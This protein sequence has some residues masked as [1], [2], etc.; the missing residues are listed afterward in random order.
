MAAPLNRVKR[1]ALI[2]GSSASIQSMISDIENAA[3]YNVNVLAT[4]PTGS[5]KELVAQALHARSGR[6]GP[7][8]SVNCAAIPRDL[9]EAEIFGHEKGAFTGAMARRIGRFEE[10]TNGTLFLDEI[11]DMPLDLQTKLLRVIEA[12][13]ISR[14]GSSK[15]TA[16][17]FRLVCA[18]HQ[19][20][21]NKVARGEFREDLMFRL[22]VIMIRVPPLKERLE[23]IPELVA[24]ISRQLETGDTGLIPPPVEPDGM[25]E[26]MKY[27]WPGNIRELKNFFQRAAV[28]SH[29]TPINR[30]F[31]RR[32]LH[33]EVSAV[34]EQAVLWEALENLTSGQD[35]R[36]AEQ[37][38]DRYLPITPTHAAIQNAIGNTNAFPLKKYLA[39]LERDIITAALK[40]SGNDTT[41]TAKHLGL[42][43]H[44]LV[45]K[46][47]KYR[48]T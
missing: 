39:T 23:D 29:G 7:L 25:S 1:D 18:T 37:S 42:R 13:T 46:M 36:S 45:S 10:A 28:L 47:G 40:H 34:D 21:Q 8:V 20:L 31:V 24:A 38:D 43:H 2:I 4:G 22:S 48:I 17:D 11:G 6:S 3:P 9:L 12:R 14:V 30:Q 27:D 41:K 32:F 33:A 16:V 19:N 35:A 15:E 26:L 44:K 5:G